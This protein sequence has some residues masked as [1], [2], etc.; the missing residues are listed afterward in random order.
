MQ[1]TEEIIANKFKFL[2]VL[3]HFHFRTWA[4][5]IVQLCLIIYI[6]YCLYFIV[7]ENETFF[8]IYYEKHKK[9]LWK[10]TIIFLLL[11]T[12]K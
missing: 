2:N 12:M 11:T 10:E 5:K 7:T 9:I 1:T 3:I 6:I 8:M 4:F